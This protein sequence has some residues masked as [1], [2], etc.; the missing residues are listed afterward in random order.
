MAR[1]FI[2]LR[3]YLDFNTNWLTILGT[4]RI[5]SENFDLH[6]YEKNLER[7]VKLCKK[8]EISD[9]YSKND[10]KVKQYRESFESFIIN[11]E[12]SLDDWPDGYFTILVIIM[13]IL[14]SLMTYHCLYKMCNHS[15]SQLC[16]MKPSHYFSN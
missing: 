2:N 16:F 13:T 9:R 11:C 3:V 5:Q 4:K 6:Q 8:Y 1:R 10:F 7:K 14:N 12:H 15:P